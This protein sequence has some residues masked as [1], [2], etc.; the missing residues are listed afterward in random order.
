MNPE[1]FAMLLEEGEGYKIE[2][3]EGVSGIDKDMV[4]F[5]NSS[6]GVIFLGITDDKQIKGINITNRL[7][8]QIQ[9][10]ANNCRPKVKIFLEEIEFDNKDVLIV[11][12]R[13]GVD[14]PYECSSGFYKRIGAIS[15]KLTR[16]ELMGF[17]KTEGK[18]RFDELINEKFIYPQDFD[19]E[20]LNSFLELAGLSE[21]LSP[22]KILISLGVAEKQENR[23]YLNH[24]GVLFFAD[25]PQKFIPWSV[26]TV[27]L[28]KDMEGVDV[29]DRKEIRGSL[30]EI[31]GKVMDFVRLYTKV[32]Y[33]FTGKPKREEI[34]EYP[35]EA[36]RE[37]VINSVMHRDY[38]EKGHNNILR[39]FPDRIL[40]ENVWIEPKG[41]ELGKT[42]FRRNHIISDLF[43]RIGFGEKLG[44]GILRMRSI[45]KNADSIEPIIEYNDSYF[46]ITFKP[47]GKYVQVTLEG[48][49][50][51][52]SL[53]ILNER[54]KKAIEQVKVKGRIT[55]K[56]YVDLN[57]VSRITATRELMDMVRKKILKQEGRGRGSRFTPMMQL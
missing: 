34:Y 48:G 57:K 18:I 53:E 55:N 25:D 44:S 28:F 45:C 49:K 19:K 50:P 27:V 14:K 1:D 12:L 39:F 24:A 4:A 30:F 9:D 2:Y 15:Q 6:G 33:K 10:I 47:S 13:E 46:W 7:K 54:Q 17:F 32:A 26:F 23:I 37:A 16:D 36:I 38:F 8:T 3:K 11:N 20:K 35:L 29:I 41:F 21:T 40:I 5:A 31:V 56:E 52:V 51:E 22:E 42:I 43:A